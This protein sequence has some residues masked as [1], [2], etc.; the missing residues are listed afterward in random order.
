MKPSILAKIEHL[1]ER[2]QEVG[3]LLGEA[4]IIA[5]QPRFRA[6]SQEYAE[7]EPIALAWREYRQLLADIDGARQLLKDA[8][9]ALRDMA[10]EELT[11]GE[12]RRDAR[13]QEPPRPLLA[14]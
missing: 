11:D 5:E 4:E 2:Y 7:I 12:T 8:D 10:E 13:E 9:A 14:T 1:S 6:L 3:A